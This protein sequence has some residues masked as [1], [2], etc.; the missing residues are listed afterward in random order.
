MT[1]TDNN[2]VTRFFQTKAIPPA[3]WNACDFVLR[4]NFKKTHIAGSVNK[5]TDILSR[6][7]LNVTEKMCLKIPEDIEIT[8]IKET[9]SS[10]DVAV[11][12]QF[13]FTEANKQ[14]ESEEQNFS[15]GKNNLEKMRRIG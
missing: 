12:E 2:S 11:E 5:A 10:A 15:N 14:K 9:T 1:L 8:P 13:I 6:L 4:F 3:P 7:E